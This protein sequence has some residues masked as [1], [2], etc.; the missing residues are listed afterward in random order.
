MKFRLMR[1]R[2]F[3]FILGQHSAEL[4]ESGLEASKVETLSEWM[5]S[6]PLGCW[7]GI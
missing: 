1:P 3:D 6:R 2:R 7:S 5:Y 4:R